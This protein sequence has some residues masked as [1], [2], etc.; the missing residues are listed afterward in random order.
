MK[1][2]GT[3]FKVIPT[4]LFLLSASIAQEMKLNVAVLDLD[5]TG[6][7]KPEALFLSDRL[8]TELFETGKFRV[9]ER[10]K[11]NGIILPEEI[12]ASG[13]QLNLYL[14]YHF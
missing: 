4:I 9:V 3:F 14:G 13:L 8:R 10:E 6:I 12:A 11:M 7:A 2:T 1:C 5:P